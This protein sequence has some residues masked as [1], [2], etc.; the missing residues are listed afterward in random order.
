MCALF[1]G[2]NTRRLIRFVPVVAF[3]I[4]SSACAADADDADPIEGGDESLTAA[5]LP[6]VAAVEIGKVHNGNVVART[7]VGAPKKVKGLVASLKKKKASEPVPECAALNPTRMRFLD[8]EG[9]AIATVE[10][11]CA[12]YASLDFH[13]DRAGYVVKIDLAAV[14]AV[15]SAPFAVGDAMWGI[16]KI[17]L[18]KGRGPDAQQRTLSGAQMKPILGGFDLDAVPDPHMIQPRCLPGY[19][20]TFKRGTDD[21]AHTSFL[22]SWYTPPASVRARFATVESGAEDGEPL[23]SGGIRIDPRPVVKLFDSN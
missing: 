19:T 1:T 20:I 4:G 23:A 21:V 7:V 14:E 5:Q 15:K 16:S 11:S 17:E 18:V 6:G 22:C 2:M 12:N 9:N 10:N 3:A 13:D 8:A